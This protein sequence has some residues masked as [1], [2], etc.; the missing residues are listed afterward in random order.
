[1]HALLA[2]RL[3]LR[4]RFSRSC[5][6][7]RGGGRAQ[8]PWAVPFAV[9]EQRARGAFENWTRTKLNK[10]SG[11][12]ALTSLQPAHVPFYVFSGRLRG[13]FT[14][15]LTYTRTERYT[16]HNG[17][18]ASRVQRDEFTREGIPFLTAVGADTAE[19]AAIYAGFDY[20]AAFVE[21]ALHGGISE[22]VLATAVPLTQAEAPASTGVGAFA[23]RPSFAFAK[24]QERL[25]SLARA[26]AEAT[27]R[28]AAANRL[29]YHKVGH[30]R[31]FG[32]GGVARPASD[33]EQPVERSVE[34][35]HA[36][37]L[38]EPRL[39]GRGVLLLPLWVAQY[40]FGGEPYRC[41]VS[42]VDAQV[43]GLTHLR[44]SDATV[45]GGA[46]GM[47]AG[48]G[49]ALVLST[50]TAAAFS[51]L[52]GAAVG[53]LTGYLMAMRRQASWEREGRRREEEAERNL[54]W[55]A[56]AF[57]QEE[58]RRVMPVPPVGGRG[59]QQRQQRQQRQGRQQL[60]QQ[61]PP[62]PPGSWRRLDEYELFGLR[63]SPPPA[64]A[65]ISSAWRREAMRWHPDHNQSLPTAELAE[66]DERSKRLNEAY[67]TLRRAARARGG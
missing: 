57:W 35:L 60:L 30:H 9:D 11:T 48:L 22:A 21:R 51:S 1:M 55:Q 59:R 18:A 44:W 52:G 10:K 36:D 34:Y 5:A 16:N 23:M 7:S 8:Q 65:D 19:Q 38:E 3:L 42:G 49:S 26:E 32:G 58:V 14:G 41:F 15:V 54:H 46:L 17:K 56:Q 61:P 50:P 29:E 24:V 27:L 2:R 45:R 25:T 31:L 40:S 67:G 64:A 12:F 39:H 4:T 20:R 13:S 63:R 62:P 28:S 53:A 33:W 37:E 6:A 66:C 43:G 47:L